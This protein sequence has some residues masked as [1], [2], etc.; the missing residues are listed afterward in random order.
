M[1]SSD[2][3]IASARQGDARSFEALIAP[4]RPAL[5]AH[6]Y[7][8]LGSPSDAEDVVQDAL[9]RAWRGLSGFDGRASLRTWLY[10]VAT[11]VCLSELERRPRR[12]SADELSP[13]AGPGAAP[14]APL[15]DV[16]WLEPCPAEYWSAAPGPE[17]R[18]AARESVTIAFLTLLQSL[19]PLQRATLVFRDVMGWSAA[20]TAEALD[21]TVPAI[22][23]ALQRARVSMERWRE[24]EA[25]NRTD[26]GELRALL[27]RYVTA[28]EAG[29]ADALARLLHEDATLTMPPLALWLK[30]RTAIGP[31]LGML[32]HQFGQVKLLETQA[33]GGPAVGFYVRGPDGAFHAQSLQVLSVTPEGLFSRLDTFMGSGSFGRFGLPLT[34]PG[35]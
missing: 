27:R 2:G 34:L 33:C 3:L 13:P 8:M 23:S 6:C 29:D 30:S 22:T 19:P 14:G 4:H 31:F 20:E 7:R 35:R 12:R 25:P 17:A 26:D 11:N 10:R 21:T 5:L 16:A 15:T 18:Y 32:I 24:G 1:E 9:V 28:W